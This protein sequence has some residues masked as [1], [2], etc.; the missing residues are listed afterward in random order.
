METGRD[1][2]VGRR[3]NFES[4]FDTVTTPIAERFFLATL[5]PRLATCSVPSWITCKNPLLCTKSVIA[6]VLSA[7]VGVR[8]LRQLNNALVHG[9]RENVRIYVRTS[10]A[11]P[12]KGCFRFT[13][14]GRKCE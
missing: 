14:A 12:F 11:C 10:G 1:P 4:E 6:T 13:Q 7:H 3:M 5:P 8:P 2:R 9:G